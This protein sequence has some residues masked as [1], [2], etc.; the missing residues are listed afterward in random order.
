MLRYK[1]LL[2]LKGVSLIAI[3]GTKLC[4]IGWKEDITYYLR[5]LGKRRAG[6]KDFCTPTLRSTQRKTILRMYR[7]RGG[8]RDPKKLLGSERTL[9][10]FN[11]FH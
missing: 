7:E 9:L 1:N 6:R 10:A 4:G 3:Y 2:K 11:C 8:G 5:F